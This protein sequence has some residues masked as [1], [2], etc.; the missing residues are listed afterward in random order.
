MRWL[1]LNSEM[2][3]KILM[4]TNSD[5]IP[6]IIPLSPS[7]GISGNRYFIAELA[8]L[9]RAEETQNNIR[10]R[11]SWKLEIPLKKG[12][13]GRFLTYPLYLLLRLRSGTG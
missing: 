4:I 10:T 6:V 1:N 12:E 2:H 8:E 5:L 3:P 13:K 9:W 7:R 11:Q